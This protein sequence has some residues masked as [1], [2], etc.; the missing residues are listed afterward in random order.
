MV[1]TFELNIKNQEFEFY[2]DHKNKSNNIKFFIIIYLKLTRNL[3]FK[4]ILVNS[5][6]ISL[7]K[8]II[9]SIL[10]RLPDEV[11]IMCTNKI[12]K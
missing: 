8:L 10:Y 2:G 6:K 3:P 11:H 12:I 9:K 4:D 5:K 1:K 7:S